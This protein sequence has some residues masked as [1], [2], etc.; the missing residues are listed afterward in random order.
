MRQYLIF[1]PLLVAANS[2]SRA[3]IEV[4]ETYSQAFERGGTL[5]IDG[6]YGALI[7]EGW[8]NSSVKLKLEKKTIKGYDFA[9]HDRFKKDLDQTLVR[10]QR[11]SPGLLRLETKFAP[12]KL[13]QRPAP[14]KSPLELVYNLM[15]PRDTKLVIRHDVGLVRIR[16][17]TGQMDVD[18]R[19]G[20]VEVSL[21][22]THNS[23]IHAVTKIGDVE[24]D[25]HPEARKKSLVGAELNDDSGRPRHRVD[26]RVGVGA[27]K[28]SRQ[29][30]ETI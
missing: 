13:L 19:R 27:I 2:P 11:V 5:E 9:D 20:E 7:I 26:L 28:I 4:L 14:G 17:V 23:S 6:S 3:P 18:S 15:V 24:S 21:P 8:S 30:P 22:A 29:I 25:F 10:F 12:S 16:E 1:V